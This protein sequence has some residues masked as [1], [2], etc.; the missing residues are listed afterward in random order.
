MRDTARGRVVW[1]A[2][3]KRHVTD[4]VG[5]GFK[6]A[7]PSK[8]VARVASWQTASRQRL[9]QSYLRALSWRLVV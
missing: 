7:W 1:D 9:E 8:A 6:A 2:Q 4:Y 5:Q 3:R